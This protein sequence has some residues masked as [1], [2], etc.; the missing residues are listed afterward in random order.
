[1]VEA[2]EIDRNDIAGCFGANDVQDLGKAFDLALFI[3]VPRPVVIAVVI[4]VGM[5]GQ[6]LDQGE[7]NQ[8][9]YRQALQFGNHERG[10]S[11]TEA[12]NLLSTILSRQQAGVLY[13]EVIASNHG[14]TEKDIETMR[15][16]TF[17]L[18]AF[19]GLTIFALPAAAESDEGSCGASISVAPAGPID[20]Q[21][22]P[23]QDATGPKAVKSA[24]KDE[25]CGNG[26]TLDGDSEDDD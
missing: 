14:R 21:A 10:V 18:L 23:M 25:A 17:L 15:N 4:L 16:S 26:Y 22:I 7:S 11:H 19:A 1:M 8:A 24:G 6:R 5:R 2:D 20:L 13:C 12:V 3:E 9:R